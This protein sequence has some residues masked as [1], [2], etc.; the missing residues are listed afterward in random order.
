MQQHEAIARTFLTALG[1][2]EV[3]TALALL[4]PDVELVDPLYGTVHGK[5]DARVYYTSLADRVRTSAY[6]IHSAAFNDVTGV[7]EYTC[8]MVLPDGRHV[9][10]P[11]ATLF[12]FSGDKIQ[13]VRSYHDP[14]LTQP[15]WRP[16]QP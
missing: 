9:D 11:A 10:L 16:E 5:A 6:D 1:N 13:A 3:E 14:A 4:A 15:I 8:H 12:E 7:L 2:K